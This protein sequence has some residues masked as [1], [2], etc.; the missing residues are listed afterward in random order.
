M[1]LYLF[2]VRQSNQNKILVFSNNNMYM[3]NQFKN[4]I[5]Y[6]SV[7]HFAKR[8]SQSIHGFGF[9]STDATISE[10]LGTARMCEPTQDALLSSKSTEDI[11][12][13]SAKETL[14]FF[15][16][17]SMCSPRNMKAHENMT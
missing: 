5:L 9:T 17:L 4:T 14:F 12:T 11:R 10:P 15:I 6:D 1:I 7:C 8:W 2:G 13:V 16:D 3:E